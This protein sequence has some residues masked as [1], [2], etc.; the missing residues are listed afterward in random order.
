MY[1]EVEY[2]KSSPATNRF[3]LCENLQIDTVFCVRFFFLEEIRLY[4]N[5]VLLQ[6]QSS[7][8]QKL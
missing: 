7:Y 1:R 6:V 3:Y 4:I 5:F 8:V 2:S